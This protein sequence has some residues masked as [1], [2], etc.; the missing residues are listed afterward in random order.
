MEG[1]RV[2]E[3][4]VSH[5]L[6]RAGASHHGIWNRLFASSADLLAVCWMKKRTGRFK[7]AER[8]G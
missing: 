1:F 5:N 2:T 3:I 6:R 4:A 8:I 7:I